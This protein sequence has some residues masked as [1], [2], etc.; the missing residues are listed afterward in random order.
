M[1]EAVGKTGINCNMLNFPSIFGSDKPSLLKF[2]HEH[3][4]ESCARVGE[5]QLEVI[6]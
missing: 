4:D 1:Q 5:L 6:G 2:M 3:Y